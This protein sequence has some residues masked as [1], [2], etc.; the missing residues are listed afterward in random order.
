MENVKF[1]FR[2]QHVISTV[3]RCGRLKFD[4]RNLFYDSEIKNI[5]FFRPRFHVPKFL[6]FQQF[7]VYKTNLITLITNNNLQK[8]ILMFHNKLQC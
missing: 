1:P 6:V 4:A 3:S 7:L 8:P 2:Q 5:Q